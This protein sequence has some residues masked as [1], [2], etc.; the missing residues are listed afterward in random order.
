M[1]WDAL[2]QKHGDRLL[3]YARQWI[4]SVPDAEETVQEGFVKFWKFSEKRHIENPLPGLYAAIKQ[5]ALDRLRSSKRRQIRED[6][7][8]ELLYGTEPVFQAEDI[9]KKE[10]RSAVEKAVESLPENQKEVL[11][12]KIW[13]DLTFSEIAESL[14][15]PQNTAASRYRYALQAMQNKLKEFRTI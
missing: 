7:A 11:V 5:C 15:I 8:G 1:D 2:V 13:A 3:L 12:M 6:T 4:K 14:D 10:L 9:E